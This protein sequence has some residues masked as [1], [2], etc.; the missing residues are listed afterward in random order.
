[1]IP[2]LLDN[3]ASVNVTD[4]DN[5]TAIELSAEGKTNA[6][7]AVTI[8][9]LRYYQQNNISLPKNIRKNINK[10]LSV[11]SGAPNTLNNN[12]NNANLM[13]ST[14]LLSSSNQF[15]NR[16]AA[17]LSSYSSAA[18]LNIN[19]TLPQQ[20][21]SK[22]ASPPRASSPLKQSPTVHSV[23]SPAASPVPPS[24]S[25]AKSIVPLS[26][27]AFSETESAP[28]TQSVS[29]SRRHNSILQ[30]KQQQAGSDDIQQIS[31]YNVDSHPDNLRSDSESPSKLRDR[32]PSVR[33]NSVLVPFIVRKLDEAPRMSFAIDPS[34]GEPLPSNS[35]S[36]KKQHRHHSVVSTS[37]A[38]AAAV[39]AVTGTRTNTRHTLMSMNTGGGVNTLESFNA[40][41]S[42]VNNG[43]NNPNLFVQT[44]TP[45][46]NTNNTPTNNQVAD[47]NI[48]MH[49]DEDLDSL[50]LDESTGP[51][52]TIAETL[53][54]PA[55]YVPLLPT[56]GSGSKYLDVILCVEHCYDC[57]SHNNQ[58]LRHD[59]TKYAKVA[60]EILFNT[61]K[62][63]I[64]HKFAIR[65]YAMR[66]KVNSLDKLG[67]M[68]VTIAINVTKP[69]P[70]SGHRNSLSTPTNKLREQ[71]KHSSVDF[72]QPH[73]KSKM[74]SAAAPSTSSLT[75][76]SVGSDVNTPRGEESGEQSPSV[77]ALP[78]DP[79]I[80][81]ATHQLFSKIDS[82]SWPTVKAVRDKAIAFLNATLKELTAVTHTIKIEK[83]PVVVAPVTSMNWRTPA[84][85]AVEEEPEEE[86][87]IVHTESLYKH[88][89][90]SVAE[91]KELQSSY[92]EWV[93][94]MKIPP[95][96]ERHRLDLD[97]P[98]LF[99]SLDAPSTA[100]GSSSNLNNPNNPRQS[101][102]Q[103]LA[104]MKHVPG[105]MLDV[106]M[107]D[108]MS[109][110]DFE[111][112]VLEHF[113]VYDS[114]I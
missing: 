13:S 30:A 43:D 63:L 26:A 68:E 36:P 37:A 16:S 27:G 93:E 21:Q 2:L 67:G 73:F 80:K 48:T 109:R 60:N 57:E 75:L 59:S 49:T 66:T 34:A 44:S 95:K 87:V 3:G 91:L 31:Q 100:G 65:L 45:F 46:S 85:A 24:K 77:S 78:V 47:P 69:L 101:L 81:W 107:P 29:T 17:T 12:N 11:P 38:V 41:R 14:N 98:D 32:S 15:N 105:P 86:V 7:Y 40:K 103:K 18:N 53:Y 33:N 52:K 71:R 6:S 61:I 8:L 4:R 50:L 106:S 20:T 70:A 19:T 5:L 58:S 114:T 22:S 42:F 9:L 72:S 76:K 56:L 113:L 79:G 10:F 88:Q 54:P 39:A 64:E 99:P 90:L 102:I 1:M 82:K 35:P 104:A 62:S 25:R 83:P 110:V 74:S 96:V 92:M 28:V 89:A 84:P 55:E 23:S 112:A 51:K 97:W 94:R 111:R 108:R